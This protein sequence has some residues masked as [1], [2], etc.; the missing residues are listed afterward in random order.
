MFSFYG[1]FFYFKPISAQKLIA[2]GE[3]TEKEKHFHVFQH[4]NFDIDKKKDNENMSTKIG[5]TG[6]DLVIIVV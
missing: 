2:A 1:K 5:M 3:K 6:A 4:I